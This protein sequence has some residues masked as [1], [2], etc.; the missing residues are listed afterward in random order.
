MLDAERAA[1]R[2]R[3][4]SVLHERSVAYK[5]PYKPKLSKSKTTLN[6]NARNVVGSSTGAVVTRTP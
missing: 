4:A 2:F 6:Q 5:S 1:V 3:V